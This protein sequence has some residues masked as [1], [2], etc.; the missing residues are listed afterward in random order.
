[1]LQTIFS[2]GYLSI[3]VACFVRFVYYCIGEPKQ[4]DTGY[5]LH[6]G[7]IFSRYGGLILKKHYEYD[8]REDKRVQAI[9]ERMTK[10]RDISEIDGTYAGSFYRPSPWMALGVCPVCFSM[11]LGI[12]TWVVLLLCL[13]ISLFWLPLAISTS[14]IILLR[15]LL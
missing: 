8:K 7:R 12:I 5:S 1:M 4:T 10:D 3:M 6:V 15:V 9:F 13:G 11:W 14:T 2:I